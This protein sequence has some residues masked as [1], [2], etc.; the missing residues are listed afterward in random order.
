MFIVVVL[1]EAAVRVSMEKMDK[2]IHVL[3]LIDDNIQCKCWDS[4]RKTEQIDWLKL[5]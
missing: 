2:V 4:T 5:N 3:I 1:Q